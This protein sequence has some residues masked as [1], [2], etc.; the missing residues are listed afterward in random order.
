MARYGLTIYVQ[1]C[2]QEKRSYRARVNRS[3]FFLWL[4]IVVEHLTVIN[5][6]S[7]NILSLSFGLCGHCAVYR[8]MVVQ[9]SL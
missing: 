8:Y 2:I 4:S 5:V 7:S 9:C 6:L 1:M 3:D